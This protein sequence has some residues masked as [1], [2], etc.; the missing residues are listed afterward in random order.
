M[1]LRKKEATHATRLTHKAFTN[2]CP[3][4]LNCL[5]LYM[6]TSF[7][8]WAFCLHLCA[9]CA[10]RSQQRTLNPLKLEL[11]V[12]VSPHGCWALNPDPLQEQQVLSTTKP[13]FQPQKGELCQRP[14]SS[15]VPFLETLS[16]SPKGNCVYFN[17]NRSSLFLIFIMWASM[18]TF[19][20]NW[21]CLPTYEHMNHANFRYNYCLLISVTTKWVFSTLIFR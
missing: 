13:S 6:Q 20:G 9:H 21:G 5:S 17:V 18:H 11:P 15:P 4:L 10:C 7:G 3:V 12:A 2:M 19:F 1:P 14:W 16:P 8:V